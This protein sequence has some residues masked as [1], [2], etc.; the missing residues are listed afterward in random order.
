MMIMNHRLSDD[1]K[2]QAEQIARELVATDDAERELPFGS[3][4]ARLWVSKSSE[5]MV[6]LHTIESKGVTVYIGPKAE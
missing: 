6:V 2:P 5:N 3:E 4:G 1:I